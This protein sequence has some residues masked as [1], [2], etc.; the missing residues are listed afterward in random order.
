LKAEIPTFHFCSGDAIT[1]PKH[2]NSQI[3]IIYR[4]EEDKSTFIWEKRIKNKR[5]IE[6]KRELKEKPINRLLRAA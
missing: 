4:D 3:A 5:K 1:C 6:S 2:K